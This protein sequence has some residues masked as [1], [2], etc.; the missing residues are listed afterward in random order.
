MVLPPAY[1]AKPRAR[2]NRGQMK[3]KSM[4]C[5]AMVGVKADSSSGSRKPAFCGRKHVE[6]STTSTPHSFKMRLKRLM[7][8]FEHFVANILCTRVYASCVPYIGSVFL[9]EVTVLWHL[10]DIINSPMAYARRFYE[11]THV[12]CGQDHNAIQLRRGRR[13]V[14]MIGVGGLTKREKCE[15]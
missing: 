14:W 2:I 10:K 5:S 6:G 1:V 4:G 11:S 7:V 9:I 8:S 13:S 12:I 15:R 3:V